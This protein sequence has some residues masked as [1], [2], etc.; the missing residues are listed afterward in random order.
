MKNLFTAAIEMVPILSLPIFVIFT[1]WLLTFGSFDLLAALRHDG[2]LV[3]NCLFIALYIAATLI[4]T[5][6]I[7]KKGDNR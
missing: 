2:A 4:R 3:V 7:C 5:D 1:S 6:E